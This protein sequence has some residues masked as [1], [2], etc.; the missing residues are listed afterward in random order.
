[1]ENPLL[2]SDVVL[3]DSSAVDLHADAICDALLTVAESIA[4]PA[5]VTNGAESFETCGEGVL[6]PFGEKEFVDKLVDV[7]T[8]EDEN[9]SLQVSQWELE[10]MRWI[11]V[12]HL[13]K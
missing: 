9:T 12:L 1:M 13:Q 4:F 2:G 10:G 5:K 3:F 8:D 11:N 6:K 7:V